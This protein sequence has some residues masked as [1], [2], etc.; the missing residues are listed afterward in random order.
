[1]F[2]YEIAQ[3]PSGEWRVECIRHDRDGEIEI[4]TFTG[5]RNEERAREFAALMNRREWLG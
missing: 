4:T 2:K 5:G 3:T 1:M